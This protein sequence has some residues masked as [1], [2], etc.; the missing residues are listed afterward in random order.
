MEEE[1]GRQKGHKQGITQYKILGKNN[2]N[3]IAEKLKA[4]DNFMLLDFSKVFKTKK[5]QNALKY[6]HIPLRAANSLFLLPKRM[7]SSEAPL[8]PKD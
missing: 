2:H 5:L 8:K 4:F 7:M 1:R 6:K 3:V